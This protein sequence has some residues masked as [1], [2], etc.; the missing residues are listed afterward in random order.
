[1]ST[2]SHALRNTLF[3]SMGIY[4]EYTLGM[5]AAVLIARELGPKH[6][7]IYG[8]F[9]WFAAIGIVVTNSGITTGV[10]KFIAEFRG[11]D[12]PQLIHPLL[13][14]M[15][16]V[17]AWHLV[18]V[19]AISMGLYL[20]LGSRYAVGLGHAELGLLIFAVAMRAPYMF[21][22]A[23]A[24]GFEAFDA[25][26]RISMVA[27]PTNLFLVVIAMLMHASI[28]WFLI[29]YAFSSMVFLLVSYVQVNRLLGPV[30][31]AG[32]ELPQ[33]LKYRIRRHL[34]LVSATIVIGFLVASDIEILFL[35]IFD[36]AT[37]AGY[38]KVAYQL[39]KGIVLLVP[40]VF[41][42]LLL[43]MM[44]K[45][46]SQ[47]QSIAG[48]R[49]V[50]A[51][52]Y[53][54]LLAMPVV[55]FGMCFSGPIID[56]L[57]GVSYA[58]AAQ[59]F[60]LVILCSGINTSTQGASSLLVSADRQQ[61]ILVLI[62][63]FG[64]MKFGLDIALIR[65]FGLHGAM[66]AIGIETAVSALAYFTIAMRVA[67]VHL[68]FSRLLRIVLAGAGASLVSLPILSLHMN[69]W[70]IL[71][72]GGGILISV[73]ATLTL[74]FGCWTE[75]DIEQL[76]ELHLRYVSGKPRVIRDLLNWASM[77]AGGRS[78]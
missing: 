8:L 15:R 60:A 37:S 55:A 72:F 7:G 28:F 17:Q 40:G 43:P 3:S 39:A 65:M 26:A 20:L 4:I 52:R 32:E 42:A 73:Y 45:A 44:A 48:R 21:N 30:P 12:T 59:V 61:T 5:V 33:I 58:P 70:F 64:F 38:F 68:D 35:N 19:F 1:M 27:A 6:Y 36:S 53:L 14:W 22:V 77:R 11:A 71:M 49:F 13:R 29:V 57:Y 69:E 31:Y 46:L 74:I 2:R 9:I 63:F 34:R 25:T 75:D 67:R 18:V 41:G 56:V 54:V 10:I 76:Q 78:K 50:A 62:I 24:K 16:R 23:I 51:T 47:S 66:L